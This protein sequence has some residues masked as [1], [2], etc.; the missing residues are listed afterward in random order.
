M[1]TSIWNKVLLVAMLF[2]SPMV[3]AQTKGL[4]DLANHRAVLNDTLQIEIVL[5]E[6]RQGIQL[7]N[8]EILLHGMA[9]DF[10]ETGKVK[11]RHAVG[12]L[13]TSYFAAAKNRKTPFNNPR[14]TTTWDFDLTTVKIKKSGSNFQVDCDLLF[15]DLALDSTKANL[16]KISE[17]FIF[18]KNGELWKL[19]NSN[20]LFK[21][22]PNILPAANQQQFIHK[23]KTADVS[24][25]AAQ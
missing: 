4:A 12:N 24:K 19:K 11:G 16:A 2:L 22:L 5:A 7:Q 25:A 17:K 15:N 9:E 18:E 20:S 13:L 6:L 1:K 23:L 8:P 14:L 3:A 21:F 10:E